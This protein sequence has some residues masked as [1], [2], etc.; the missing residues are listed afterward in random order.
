MEISKIANKARASISWYCMNECH[1][2]CCRKSHLPLTQ[3]EEKYFSKHLTKEQHDNRIK[4]SE[5]GY[6]MDLK[7]GCIFLR[8]DFGC[9]IHKS[10]H[11]PK[12][13][14][15]FPIY[16][17]DNHVFIAS[18]CSA[19]KDGKLYPYVRRMK[20]EGAIIIEGTLESTSDYAQKKELLS[21]LKIKKM[22]I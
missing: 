4:P 21:T 5:F 3:K 2:M 8:E 13:C 12:T 20:Q 19:V 16:I 17:K 14:S 22:D 10:T 7:E 9:S 6:T 1:A 15:D 18:K 11:K